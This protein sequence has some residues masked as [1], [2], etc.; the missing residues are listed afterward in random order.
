MS[1]WILYD[2]EDGVCSD[3]ND[4]SAALSQHLRHHTLSRVN[5]GAGIQVHQEIPGL[6]RGFMHGFPS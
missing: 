1:D 2:V 6:V 5:N 4:F 3:I